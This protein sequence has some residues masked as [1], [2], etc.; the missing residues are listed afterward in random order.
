MKKKP[1]RKRTLPKLKPK[2]VKKTA[3]LVKKAVKK[4]RKAKAARAHLRKPEMATKKDD[5]K[6]KTDVTNAP[7]QPALKPD[8]TPYEDGVDPMAAPP[9]GPLSPSEASRLDQGGEVDLSG[10][11]G[12]AGEHVPVIEPEAPRDTPPRTPKDPKD[13]A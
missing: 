8:G 9:D 1:A 10:S 12:S 11:P 6:Q 2:T 4:V 5:D 7:D 3:A 13:A